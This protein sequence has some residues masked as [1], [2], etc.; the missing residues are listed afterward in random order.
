MTSKKQSGKKVKRFTLHG[1][2]A[3]VAVIGILLIEEGCN[4]DE[5]MVGPVSDMP[6]VASGMRVEA[7]GGAVLRAASSYDDPVYAL[8]PGPKDFNDLQAQASATIPGGFGG[9][10]QDGNGGTVVWLKDPSKSTVALD[11]LMGFQPADVKDYHRVSRGGV[12]FAQGTYDWRDLNVWFKRAISV[13]R[14][15]VV[16]MDIDERTNRIW[17]GVT[18]TA[19]EDDLRTALAGENV[20]AGAVTIEHHSGIVPSRGVPSREYPTVPTEAQTMTLRSNFDPPYHSGIL[21]QGTGV[22]AACTMGAIVRLTSS[23]NGFLTTSH[24]TDVMFR[25]DGND[26][27]QPTPTGGD[28]IGEEYDDH[29]RIQH[30]SCEVGESCRL[31]DAALVEFDDADD[32]DDRGHIARTT[33]IGGVVPLSRTVSFCG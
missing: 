25:D 29:G 11:A 31:S 18:N 28:N 20:P 9:A 22:P 26:H 12:T 4:S 33:G 6:D 7:E 15:G 2:V 1:A 3:V 30:D 17:I 19:I 23:K 14:D 21:Q 27:Y 5:G 16:G 8:Q 13:W 24:C 10:Y 32:G